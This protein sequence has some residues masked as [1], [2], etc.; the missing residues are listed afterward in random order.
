MALILTSPHCVYCGDPARSAD[1]FIPVSQQQEG[2]HNFEVPCC[3]SCNGIAGCKRF[4]TFDAKWY[5]VQGR[6]ARLGKSV[7]LAITRELKEQVEKTIPT[8]IETDSPR[9]ALR[10]KKNSN[11]ITLRE[12]INRHFNLGDKTKEK[13]QIMPIRLTPTATHASILPSK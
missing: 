3:Y 6:R 8:H 4:A 12:A 11:K 13:V 1:H 5:H 7:N 9:T 10:R 2:E